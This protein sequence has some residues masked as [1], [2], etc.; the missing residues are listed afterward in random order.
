MPEVATRLAALR[1]GRID[2][3]GPYQG[4][5]LSTL[6]QVESLERTNPELVIHPIT[7]RSNN[8]I[9]MNVQLPPFDEIRV[10]KALQMAINLEEINR[11]LLWR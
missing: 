7:S 4:S 10:R 1:T 2:Y 9:G 8:A 3:I 6:D 5:A 11:A